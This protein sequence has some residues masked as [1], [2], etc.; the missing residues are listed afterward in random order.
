MK[1]LP[2]EYPR[3]VL[4]AVTGL[5]PQIVTETLYALIHQKPY[6][7]VPTELRLVTTQE[8]ANLATETL[9]A[10]ETGKFSQFCKEYD[11]S[12]KIRFDAESICVIK[13]E[14][15][16]YL[17]D[18][19]APEDNVIA[20]DMITNTLRELTSDPTCA[21]HVSIA[22]GRK[23]MGFY[24][25]Y[26]LSIFARLQDRLS[27]VLVSKEF[28]TQKEFFFPTTRSTLLTTKNG[29]T[30]DAS[31]ALVT[32]ADI[33]FIRMRNNLSIKTTTTYKDIVERLNMAMSGPK[34]LL[35]E[36][37]RTVFLNGIMVELKPQ[38]FAYY[39]WLIKRLKNMGDDHWFHWKDNDSKREYSDCYQKLFGDPL[40]SGRAGQIEESIA[41]MEITEEM[42]QN[43]N[44]INREK[45]LEKS[46]KYFEGLKSATN[47]VL[48]EILK[49]T[50]EPFI[51]ELSP[52]KIGHYR[53]QG[54][55]QLM[56][57]HI[58]ILGDKQT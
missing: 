45:A 55:R 2:H 57:E 26:A 35:D 32:L 17:D 12:G 43:E 42:T 52:E 1:K 10:P 50:V 19:R 40:F 37:K 56:P 53:Y 28:E 31:R 22:G 51:I 41:E 4:V 23:T 29:R 54:F 15:G 30:L 58:E 20:A 49:K 6:R 11:L 27:H 34:V 14:A 36:I 48:K 25:G 16:E 18:I 13:S 38:H 9:L 33:P 46:R 5:S 7:F 39:A 3:R 44:S 21:V 8:G 24:I 47:K